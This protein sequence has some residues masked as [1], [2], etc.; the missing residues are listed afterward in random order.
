MLLYTAGLRAGEVC[1]LTVSSIDWEGEIVVGKGGSERTV[2]LHPLAAETV[3]ACL[4]YARPS[5]RR[6]RRFS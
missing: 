4:R 1:R 5:L 2:P 6:T 3:R